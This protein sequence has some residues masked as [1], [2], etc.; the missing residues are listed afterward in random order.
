MLFK[1]LYTVQKRNSAVPALP[2]IDCIFP[3]QFLVI[4][5]LRN[6][7]MVE[8]GT[9][10]HILTSHHCCSLIYHL[11]ENVSFMI[12]FSMLHYIWALFFLGSVLLGVELIGTSGFIVALKG[13][14]G[15]FPFF[16]WN[17]NVSIS[18]LLICRQERSVKGT[19]QSQ[20]QGGPQSWGKEQQH[21]VLIK[22]E[23]EIL[24]RL[25]ASKTGWVGEAAKS[26]RG[27]QD[28]GQE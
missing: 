12:F 16:H 8:H 10:C 24:S 5:T 20:W 26:S 9:K 1:E 7:E 23:D 21:K 19:L 22:E 14:G 13:G 11:R 6:M 17:G 2:I 25:A 4:R 3:L 27:Q 28:L 15:E 18:K